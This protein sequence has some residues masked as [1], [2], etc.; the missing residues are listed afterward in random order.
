VRLRRRDTGLDRACVVNVAQ[1]APLHRSA[2]SE[3]VS[4]LT[5][6]RLAEVEEG[7][8]LVL[9]LDRSGFI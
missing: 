2:F 9:G 8:R 4:R 7:L 3:R 6:A 5:G 1:L